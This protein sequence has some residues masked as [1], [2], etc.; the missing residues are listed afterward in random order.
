MEDKFIQFTSIFLIFLFITNHYN[1]T[2]IIY[3]V[4]GLRAQY[5]IQ[6]FDKVYMIHLVI[7]ITPTSVGM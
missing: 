2:Y 6:L 3:I 4:K 7:T 5:S 1:G